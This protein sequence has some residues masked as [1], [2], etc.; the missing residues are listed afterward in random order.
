M[1][2]LIIAILLFCIALYYFMA[3]RSTPSSAPRSQS[4]V[5]RQSPKPAPA[6][7][8]V[9]APVAASTAAVQVP[10]RAEPEIVT[11]RSPKNK[12][13]VLHFKLQNGLMIVQGDQV[14]G[15]P[16]RPDVPETGLVQIPPVTLWPRGNVPYH[17]QPSVPNP[18]RVMEAIA[19]FDGTAIHLTP[20]KNEDD[21]LVFEP[22]DKDCLSYVGK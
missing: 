11:E 10:S 14:A 5:T 18:E 9:D 17:I 3:D 20:Y 6:P 22:G 15:A 8:A 1:K 16:T 2:K 7:A 19:M 12:K 4:R 13:P 21:V